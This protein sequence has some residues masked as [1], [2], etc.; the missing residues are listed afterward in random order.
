MYKTLFKV[1]PLSCALILAIWAG[2]GHLN[3]ITEPVNSGKGIAMLNISA[4]AGVPF[5][6]LAKKATLSISANDM[7]TMTN[8]LTITDSSVVGTITGI[9]AGKSRLFTVS[10]YDS[11]DTLQYRGSSIANVIV[12]STIKVSI[13]V[14]RI[15]GNATING[16]IFESQDSVKD[17]DGNVYHTIKIG[18]QTWLIEN[19]KTTK[20]NDSTP[21]PLVT[22]SVSWISLSTPAYCW[23]KNDST[24]YKTTY[25]ALYNWHAVNTGKLAPAGWHIPSDSEWTILTTFLGGE[26]VA[27]GK[28]KEMGTAHWQSPNTGATNESGFTALPGGEREHTIINGTWGLFGTHGTWW[29]TTPSTVANAAWYRYIQNT[30]ANVFRSPNGDKNYGF[31]VRCIKN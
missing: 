1:L 2:C 21:I 27:A 16:N 24:T 12:D 8:L 10:I 17:M 11:F 20:Y 22:D 25:G 15:S 29:S 28:I 26:S 9:P 6:M 5:K 3:Q 23:F 7:I 13:N 18:S 31:S 4:A 30:G 19:L 14:V